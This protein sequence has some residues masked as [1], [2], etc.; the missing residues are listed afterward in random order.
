MF[1][2]L[3]AEMMVLTAGIGDGI[4][5]LISLCYQSTLGCLFI[6]EDGFFIVNRYMYV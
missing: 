2:S 4:L 6:H 5:A 1:P 3:P